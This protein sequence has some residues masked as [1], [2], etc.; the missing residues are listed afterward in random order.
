MNDGRG[1]VCERFCLGR[2]GNAKKRKARANPGPFNPF[3]HSQPPPPYPPF[4]YLRIHDDDHLVEQRLPLARRPDALPDIGDGRVV[5]LHAPFVQ[6]L[7]LP[8][9]LVP[10]TPLTRRHRL[11]QRPQL[12]RN[13]ASRRPVR[14]RSLRR[15]SRRGAV[16]E[17][18]RLRSLRFRGPQR[19]GVHLCYPGRHDVPK[20]LLQ[21]RRIFV[22]HRPGHVVLLGVV[23][24][25]FHVL[26]QSSD[27][28]LV[29]LVLVRA[30]VDSPLHHV[31]AHW[32]LDHLI[33][34]AVMH[35][36]K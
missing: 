23:E 19:R 24:N 20:D 3:T 30:A 25:E 16:Q 6:L 11:P 35:L 34:V 1:R 32:L 21:L 17:E 5:D 33:V 26:P 15:P 12:L 31:Q 13:F 29:P 27:P 9:L 18:R 7:L 10:V 2:G 22:H 28:G 8:R 36:R 14:Q 4:T